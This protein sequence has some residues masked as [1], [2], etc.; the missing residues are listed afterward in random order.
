MTGKQVLSAETQTRNE[1]EITEEECR[2]FVSFIINEEIF[3]VDVL[4]VHE[5]IGMT[6]VTPVPNSISYMKGVI[7]MR[8]NV[9][10]VVDM[11]QKFGLPEIDYTQITVIIIVEVKGMFIG[12]IVDTVSD[13]VNLPLSR[14]HESHKFNT[15]IESEFIQAI[16][17]TDEDLIIIL[18]VE[19]ILDIENFEKQA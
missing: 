17:Q 19:K 9:V 11:R 7:N 2:E 5:I 18:N 15:Q 12:M 16:G 10:P 8:G 14:I 4:Q 6:D 13:V 1:I 3:G